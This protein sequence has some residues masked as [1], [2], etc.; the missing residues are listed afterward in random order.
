MLWRHVVLF[1]SYAVFNRRLGVSVHQLP[2][3]CL[4]RGVAPLEIFRTTVQGVKRSDFMAVT[5]ISSVNP[6]AAVAPKPAVQPTS[7]A[8]LGKQ[9]AVKQAA[10]KADEDKWRLAQEA[11]QRAQ[12][13]SEQQSQQRVQGNK[14]GSV[15]TMA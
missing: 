11:Q 4:R 6:L 14:G 2:G 3:A 7:Q 12:Q 9:Q 15:N 5:S 10:R 13:Q 1:H 8:E